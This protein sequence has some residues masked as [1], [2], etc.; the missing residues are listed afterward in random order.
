MLRVDL[1][2]LF[3]ELIWIHDRGLGTSTRNLI[4]RLNGLEDVI[5]LEHTKSVDHLSLIISLVI[6]DALCLW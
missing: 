6:K 3:L 5:S 2:K 1:L 4:D